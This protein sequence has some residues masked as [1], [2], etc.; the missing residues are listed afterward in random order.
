VKLILIINLFI[1]NY[2]FRDS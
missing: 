2:K 1:L